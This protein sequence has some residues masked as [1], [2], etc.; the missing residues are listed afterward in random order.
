MGQSGG[1]AKVTCTIAMPA[2]KGL[3]HKGVAL[4]GSML[5]ANSQEYSRKLGS[6]VLEAAGLGPTEVDKLQDIPWRAYIDVANKALDRMRKE[7]PL[8]GFRGGF[9]PVADGVHVPTGEFFAD[10]KD[11]T[12]S[13][14]LMICTTFHECSARSSWG[15]RNH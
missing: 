11:H 6:F 5:K 4:S 10:P 12:A 3:V 8:P 15:I 7:N 1:G 14:P 13:I 2:A 9:G